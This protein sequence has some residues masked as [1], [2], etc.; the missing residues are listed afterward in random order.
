MYI[1]VWSFV[2]L[3]FQWVKMPVISAD[4]LCVLLL[5]IL[6]LD[7][8]EG[9][10]FN[11]WCKYLSFLSWLVSQFSSHSTATVSIFDIYFILSIL[12][13]LYGY[14]SVGKFVWPKV[15]SE[16]S[17]NIRS[18]V[19]VFTWCLSVL[20]TSVFSLSLFTW[21]TAHTSTPAPLSCYPAVLFRLPVLC[22]SQYPV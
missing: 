8:K 11:Y 7:L 20:S 2:Q 12:F 16:F 10:L 15:V 22:S 21:S 4:F 13:S 18:R 9:L 5:A 14:C 17:P 3:K 6:S 1:C 19:V